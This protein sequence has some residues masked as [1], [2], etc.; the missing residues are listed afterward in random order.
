M[1]YELDLCFN[2]D[3]VRVFSAY[4]LQFSPMMDEEGR[5]AIFCSSRSPATAEKGPL[6]D[7]KVEN[8]CRLSV[9]TAQ[10]TVHSAQC[11]SA[12]STLL[13]DNEESFIRE[14]TRV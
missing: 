14:S 12:H 4:L 5:K 10:C 13:E 3:C 1:I 6:R 2:N 8:D 7:L 9:H 11:G